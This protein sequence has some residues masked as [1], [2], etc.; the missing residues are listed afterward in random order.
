MTTPLTVSVVVPVYNGAGFV[1]RAVESCLG[2]RSAGLAVE[3]VAVDDASADASADVLASF[4]DTVRLARRESNAGRC[5]SRNHGLD[6]ATGT[7]VKFLDQDDFLEPG[8]LLPEAEAAARDGADVVAAGHRMAHLSAEGDWVTTLLVPAPAFRTTPDGLLAGLSV[9]TA[10]ALY[11][12]AYV[13]DLRWDGRFRKLDD[14]DWFVRAALRWGKIVTV[15]H[16]SYCWVQH[17]SQASR[18]FSALD[19]A[20]EFYAILDEL[21][22]DL[23]RTGQLTEPRKRR[24][25]QYLYKEL[26]TLY[27]CGDAPGF[28]RRLR[29]IRELDPHFAPHDEE[30]R[31]LVRV[32]ARVLGVRA[33]LGV[34]GLLRAWYGRL[35][36]TQ[37]ADR[38]G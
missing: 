29:Q 26:D 12:R 17:S 21:A 8:T 4:G 37:H 6:L 31:R 30:P 19:H 14:W 25:A 3:V 10:A 16:T 35:R 1:R 38:V 22:D 34:Y 20:H 32:L 9:P 36:T 2:Q 15:R 13:Q 24:L 5:A 23:A 33:A 28:E 11:R 27:R 7:Y 18:N